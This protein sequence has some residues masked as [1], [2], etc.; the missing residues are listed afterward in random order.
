MKRQSEFNSIDRSL[1]KLEYQMEWSME[2]SHLVRDK[3][4]KDIKKL[5]KRKIIQNGLIY[6]SSFTL[7][8]VFIFILAGQING[9][10]NMIDFS[11][12][13]NETRAPVEALYKY[14][15]LD[16]GVNWPTLTE[17]G[18][19]YVVFPQDAEMHIQTIMGKPDIYVNNADKDRIAMSATY[20]TTTPGRFVEIDTQFNEYGSIE[21][22]IAGRLVHKKYSSYSYKTKELIVGNQRAVL[23]EP[24]KEKGYGGIKLSIVTEDYIYTIRSYWIN[25]IQIINS[26]ELI[27]ELIALGELFHFENEY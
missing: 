19:K 6:S 4:R 1:Q 14:K 5:K 13:S 16:N 3:V 25:G 23:Q 10:V 2:R 24:T 26:E 8:A 22:G 27:S 17:L 11:S 18:E 20:S 15:N 7:V 9:K 21:E 12:S